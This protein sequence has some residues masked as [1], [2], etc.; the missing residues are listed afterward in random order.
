M[1]L[2]LI[3]LQISIIN[4]IY[5]N[6]DSGFTD[7][8]LMVIGS[9]CDV[10][11]GS[12]T[13]GLNALREMNASDLTDSLADSVTGL[14]SDD[15]TTAV[16]GDE[17]AADDYFMLGNSSSSGSFDGEFNYDSLWDVDG[18]ILDQLCVCAECGKENQLTGITNNCVPR[19]CVAEWIMDP[20]RQ[21]YL[22]LSFFSLMA[23][24]SLCAVL[25]WTYVSELDEDDKELKVKK[26]KGKKR[27]NGKKGKHGYAEDEAA[28]PKIAAARAWDALQTLKDNAPGALLAGE[29]LQ[30]KARHEAKSLTN[31]WYFEGTVLFACV[32]NV[33]VLAIQS[34]TAPPSKDLA[35][36]LRIGEI[37]VALFL[38]VEVFIEVAISMTNAERKKVF[39]DPWLTIDFIVLFASWCYIWEVYS[40][41]MRVFSIGRVLR[42]LRPLRTLRMLSSI[43]TVIETIMEALPLFGQACLLVSFLLMAYALV[44]MSLWGGGLHFK[45]GLPV[46]SAIDTTEYTCPV[47]ISGCS[48]SCSRIEPPPYIRSEEYGF[49]GFDS[50]QQAML[51]MFVQMTG[52][53]GMQDVPLALVGANVALSGSAWMTMATAVGVLT[54][55]ALNLFLAVCCSV[56]DAVHDKITVA[57]KSV[58]RRDIEYNGEFASATDKK[59]GK[60][61]NEIM[62]LMGFVAQANMQAKETAMLAGQKA[63]QDLLTEEEKF[64]AYQAQ[65]HT[66]DWQALGGHIGSYRNKCKNIALSAKYEKLINCVI[67][68]NALALMMNHHGISNQWLAMNLLIESLCLLFFWFEFLFKWLGFGIKTYFSEQT[69]KL[70]FF[71]LIC[72]SAGFLGGVFTV[73]ETILGELPGYEKVFEGLRALTSLRLIKLMRALQ[74][75]RWI[76]THPQMRGL[77]ETVFTS[78][79][80]MIL[81]AIFSMFS[82]VMFAVVAMHLLGGALGDYPTVTLDD[83]PRRHIETFWGAMLTMFQF[84]TGEAWS[85]TMYWYME[86]NDYIPQYATAMFWVIVFVWL[87]CILFSLFVAVL[88]VNFGVDDDEKIPRQ[89]IKYERDQK[90]AQAKHKVT[91]HLLKA[92]K[93]EAQRLEGDEEEEKLNSHRALVDADVV[94]PFTQG[95]PKDMNRCSLHYFDISHPF[96]LHCAR[97][98]SHPWFEGIVTAMVLFSCFV[99]AFESP[100]LMSKY[101]YIFEVFNALILFIFVAEMCVKIVVHGFSNTSGPTAPYL[102]DKTNRLDLFVIVAVSFTYIL[103]MIHADMSELRM[104]RLIRVLTPMLQLMRNES[105]AA[106]IKTFVMAMPAVGHCVALLM[107]LLTVFGIVGVEYFRGKLY[108]CVDAI[109]KSPMTHFDL[110]NGGEVFIENRTMCLEHP[111]AAWENPAFNFDNII[112]AGMTIFYLAVTAGWVDVMEA[113]M[114]TTEVDRSP[115]MDYSSGYVAYFVCFHVVFTFFLLNLF[116]GVLSSA[117]AAQSGSNLVTTLQR[118]WIRALMMIKTFHPASSQIDKPEVGVRLWKLRQNMWDLAENQVLDMVWT[119]GILVNVAILMLD[120]YPADEEWLVFVEWFN[121]VC[122]L[123]FTLEFAIKTLGYGFYDY[124]GNRW[125]RLDFF[126]I[127]GSWGS[128]FFGVKA[129]LGVVRCFRVVRL[130][131]LVKRM[132]GLMSLVDTIVACIKPSLDI[133]AISSLFFYLYAVIGVKF[134]GVPVCNPVC[135]SNA[136]QE[137]FTDFISAM[138]ILFQLINGQTIYGIVYDLQQFGDY[139]PFVYVSTFYFLLVWICENLLVVTVLD[140]FSVLASMDGDHFSPDDLDDFA[141][142]WHDLTYARVHTVT[143]EQTGMFITDDMV[144]NLSRHEL[145]LLFEEKVEKEEK[146]RLQQWAKFKESFIN[147]RYKPDSIFRGWLNRPKAMFTEKRYFWVSSSWAEPRSEAYKT[148]N[149]FED[150]SSERQLEEKFEKLGKG[151][152]LM[153]YRG[154]VLKVHTPLPT[155][156][157]DEAPS[158]LDLAIGLDV[159]IDG[160]VNKLAAAVSGRPWLVSIANSQEHHHENTMAQCFDLEWYEKVLGDPNARPP[161]PIKVHDIEIPQTASIQM[162]DDITPAQVRLL[163]CIQIGVKIPTHD[164]GIFIRRQHDYR[165]FWPYFSRVLEKVHP[166]FE[167]ASSTHESDWDL[168][169]HT[170]DDE[171]L[172]AEEGADSEH[173]PTFAEVDLK[174]MAV[175]LSVSRNFTGF[176]LVP[177]MTRTERTTVEDLMTTLIGSMIDRPEWSGRYVSLTPGHPDY[178]DDKEYKKLVKDGLMFSPATDDHVMTEGGLATDWPHGRGAY[179]SADEL[180]TIY[181]GFED[182]LCINSVDNNASD[183]HELLERLRISLLLVSVAPTNEKTVSFMYDPLCGFVNTSLGNAGTGM[184]ASATIALQKLTVDGTADRVREVIKEQDIGLMV[185]KRKHQAA[186]SVLPSGMSLGG[187]GGLGGSMAELEKFSGGLAGDAF[188]QEV[189]SD[190]LVE[191]GVQQTCGITEAEIVRILQ[192]GLIKLAEA[193]SA[194][195]V[196]G[197]M[198]HGS[199]GRWIAR[200]WGRLKRYTNTAARKSMKLQREMQELAEESARAVAT[201]TLELAE[202]SLKMAEG[203]ANEAV[204]ELGSLEKSITGSP[205][206]D[207]FESDVVESI[208][209]ENDNPDSP[210]HKNLSDNVLAIE[211]DIEILTVSRKAQQAELKKREQQKLHVRGIRDSTEDDL[212]SFFTTFGPVERVVKMRRRKE[213]HENSENTSYAIVH[214]QAPEGAKAALKARARDKTVVYGSLSLLINPFDDETS[215]KSSGNMALTRLESEHQASK[216]LNQSTM[217]SKKTKRWRLLADSKEQ[218][219]SWLV[220]LHWLADDCPE[221][222]PHHKHDSRMFPGGIAPRTLTTREWTTLKSDIGLLDLPFSM[223]RTFL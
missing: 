60:A 47:C 169:V 109:E 74:L 80:S 93:A 90:A 111:G 97:I 67:G 175:T 55:L 102:K 176:S 152:Q 75:S 112:Q 88:L 65:I 201:K 91:S 8:F 71:V 81:V 142:V 22:A 122:L 21:T 171:D 101:G 36:V 11:A 149:W 57:P 38:T 33:L 5:D 215:K 29:D 185:I 155:K 154:K 95:Q 207:D 39:R 123:V 82:M 32:I 42:V 132:P 56:F 10:N 99:I 3:L 205:V 199:I 118:K 98:E 110:A 194:E 89:R 20:A 181:V 177:A 24:E 23:F 178:I 127:I 27:K 140:N 197:T 212:R 76:Y 195:H 218:R 50:F 121:L 160:R 54:I 203:L 73:M 208:D 116:I 217:N 182:H 41:W 40:E 216:R 153:Q 130:F 2:V 125:N 167:A 96:R 53:N 200:V 196:L 66:Q 68:L 183:L 70:D 186:A 51:T 117:F 223:F 147:A 72:C 128:K 94:A 83:Y 104:L 191:V 214:M 113:V 62:N 209:G 45:C 179:I 184:A 148:L 144:S 138:K 141:A 37:F 78:W 58:I 145:T 170:G 69:N 19:E 126:V 124:M 162:H 120:H 64:T 221:P 165:T 6:L 34:P 52:D 119:G 189:H 157:E 159:T 105:L 198:S 129:G 135:E 173:F 188:E 220:V 219:D 136:T 222:A 180:V 25:A 192:N 87:R 14:I 163:Q 31:T 211:F 26:R 150:G 103:P 46:G 77:L 48:S 63:R 1:L 92:I 202:E 158:K 30:A 193:E 213:D 84:L 15:N 137:Q 161:T 172:M 151:V 4:V 35:I 79:Q 115:Q 131:L 156:P 210:T 28:S 7:Q 143:P 114:D 174:P 204:G 13:E 146:I 18:S 206:Q 187:L 134:F 166:G 12:L 190:G 86:N 168:D 9:L 49:T 85:T 61:D 100:E 133:A 107:V 164:V 108:R 44:G 17:D 59:Y 16:G 106:L 139:L 43:G